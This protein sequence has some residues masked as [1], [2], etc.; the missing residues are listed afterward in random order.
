MRAR[1]QNVTSMPIPLIFQ[2]SALA[3]VYTVTDIEDAYLVV[4]N[5]A[6]S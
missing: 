2:I 6:A 5:S 4:P 3:G 1:W